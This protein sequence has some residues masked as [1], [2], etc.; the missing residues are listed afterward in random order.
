MKGGEAKA[1]SAHCAVDQ[2]SGV[3]ADNIENPAE[4]AGLMQQPRQG[5]IKQVE[6][7]RER[8]AVEQLARL[9]RGVDGI[10]DQRLR[11]PQRQQPGLILILSLSLSRAR[12]SR[13]GTH[14]PTQAK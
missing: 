9:H 4:P 12:S 13:T 2:P 3:V 10:Q 14:R 8:K 6:Q 11:E 5:A 7:E 1:G